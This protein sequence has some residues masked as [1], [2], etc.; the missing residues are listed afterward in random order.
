[1]KNMNIV[2]SIDLFMERSLTLILDLDVAL[3]TLR[4][5]LQSLLMK[6]CINQQS[7][8][9]LI[10]FVVISAKHLKRP[11]KRI[12]QFSFFRI[13]PKNPCLGFFGLLAFF[14]VIWKELV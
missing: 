13:P 12:K 11:Q 2:N 9:V 7:T 4:V 14:P 5:F 3:K 6:A 10:T 8:K 1:M